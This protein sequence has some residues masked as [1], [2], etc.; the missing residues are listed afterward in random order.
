MSSEVSLQINLIFLV[1]SSFYIGFVLWKNRK[2]LQI[3]YE[4]V[5]DYI[6]LNIIASISFSR[7]LYV[8]E[9]LDTFKGISWSI[10]PYYFD[11]GAQRIWLKQMPWII[12]KFWGGE[13][14]YSG[15]FLGELIFS[16]LF[17]Y[18]KGL[19]KKFI[20][21]LIN[22]LC[23]SQ[24]IQAFGF[25]ITGVYVGKVTDYFI[26]VVYPQRFNRRL[27]LQ[28]I[29]VVFLLLLI[30][31]FQFLRKKGKQSGIMGI[32]LFAF[33]WLQIIVSYLKEQGEKK[34]DINL[35]QVIYL[36]LVF[37]GIIITIFAYQEKSSDLQ[38]IQSNGRKFI[39]NQNSM[40]K[41]TL[42]TSYRDYQSSYSNYQKSKPSLVAWIKRKFLSKRK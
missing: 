39:D 17:Y 33:G 37:V 5:F 20:F 38:N 32:Y 30:Y 11:P 24:I 40:R 22:A 36:L 34:V 31:L 23:V 7:L 26:G 12:L 42:S 27:P 13:I 1:I 29:E 21:Y 2:L 14:N 10:Y 16:L 6:L 8:F 35:L 18:R 28:L 19:P 3:R 4:I 25:F 15:I 9:N 41:E